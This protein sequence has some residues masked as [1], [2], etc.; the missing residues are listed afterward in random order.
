MKILDLKNSNESCGGKAY[1]LAK[2]I[3]CNINVPKG[4]VILESQK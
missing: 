4:F 2:L 1:G 3:N